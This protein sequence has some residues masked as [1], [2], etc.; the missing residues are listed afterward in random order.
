MKAEY[1]SHKEVGSFEIVPLSPGARALPCV[2]AYDLKIDKDLRPIRLK[3]RVCCGGHRVRWGVG[4]FCKHS[5]TTSLDAFR[6]FLVVAASRGWA[7]YEDDYK[8]A[9]LNAPIGSIKE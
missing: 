8:T 1:D 3:A 5:S 6:I 2:W 9:Y 4:Y 7:I